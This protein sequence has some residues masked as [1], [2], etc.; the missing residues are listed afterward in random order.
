M[1]KAMSDLPEHCVRSPVHDARPSQPGERD[2]QFRVVMAFRPDRNGVPFCR[3]SVPF[4]RND[5]PPTT[6]NTAPALGFRT[7]RRP[8]PFFYLLS[9]SN[10]LWTTTAPSPR[11]PPQSN[12]RP[13]LPA[14]PARGSRIFGLRSTAC[15]QPATG[16][17]SFSLGQG[18]SG[19]RQARKGYGREE[20]VGGC[21]TPAARP[22]LSTP[23][24]CGQRSRPRAGAGAPQPYA[25]RV[26]F[27]RPLRAIAPLFDTNL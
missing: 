12:G 15:S 20:Q 14:R 3:N 24:R 19:L 22:G 23:S 10:F 6:R 21:G 1:D 2:G 8:L 18:P 27:P 11:R 26:A 4:Y 13:S 5:V 16:D 25:P 7:S 9:T 17:V